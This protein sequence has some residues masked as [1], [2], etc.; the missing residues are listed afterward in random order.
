MFHNLRDL[1]NYSFTISNTKTNNNFSSLFFLILPFYIVAL[2]RDLVNIYFSLN[3][4]LLSNPPTHNNIN[5]NIEINTPRD[6]SSI[7][8]I[9]NFRELLVNLSALFILYV[10]RMLALNNSPF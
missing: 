8:S 6:Q 5:I 7:S 4:S 3:L 2:E 9:N 10:K 1:I